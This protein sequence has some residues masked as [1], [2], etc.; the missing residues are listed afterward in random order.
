[1][2]ALGKL[3]WFHAVLNRGGPRLRSSDSGFVRLSETGMDGISIVGGPSAKGCSG[4]CG[5]SVA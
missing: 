2:V 4:D 5:R 1:M 3:E